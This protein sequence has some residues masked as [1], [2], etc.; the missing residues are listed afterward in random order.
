[1]HPWGL[2]V[3]VSGVLAQFHLFSLPTTLKGCQNRVG[4]TMTPI[5]FGRSVNPIAIMPATLLFAL[6]EISDLPTALLYQS[7]QPFPIEFHQIPALFLLASLS[8][9]LLLSVSAYKGR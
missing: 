5:H 9:T 8:L 4:G 1:M 7:P 6:P 2:E 3:R